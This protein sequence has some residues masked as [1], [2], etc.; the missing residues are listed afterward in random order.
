MTW[1]PFIRKFG[2]PMISIDYQLSPEA[3]FKTAILECESVLHT[4]YNEK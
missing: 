2:A 4:I 3:K 1:I